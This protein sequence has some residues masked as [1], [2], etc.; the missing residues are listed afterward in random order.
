LKQY[1]CLLL[2]TLLASLPVANAQTVTGSVVGSV[3]DAGG[4][5][6]AGAKVE[7]I[8]NISKQAREFQSS[9]VGSFEFNGMIPGGYTLKVSHKGFNI[10]EQAVTISAQERVDVHT[11]RLG[12][13]NV[14]TSV[15]VKAELAHIDTSSSDRAQN[16]NLTQIGDTP[17]R[18]CNFMAVLKTLPGVQDL[19]VHDSRGWGCI[20]PT[21][22]GGQMGQV[23]VLLDGIVSQD[24]GAPS[25]NGYIAPSVD[26]VGEVKLLTGNQAGGYL[27]K[28]EVKGTGGS[29]VFHESS[30]QP[31]TLSFSGDRSKADELGCDSCP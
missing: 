26:A 31:R 28:V 29:R 2:T 18:G 4:A 21:I 1:R 16:V 27:A 8:N 22:N 24:S 12:V 3:A 13:G 15:D 9:T 30:P 17:I 7:L 19:G 20:T 5:M 6:I 23:V 10:Y 14:T 25:I 11:L